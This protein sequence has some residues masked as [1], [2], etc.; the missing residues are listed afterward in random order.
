MKNILITGSKGQLGNDLQVLFKKSEL[1]NLVNAHFT[2]VDT[3]DICDKNQLHAIFTKHKFAYVVNCAA[4]TAVDKAETEF[5]KAMLVNS[6]APHLL[7]D[8]CNEFETKLIHISTDYVFDG[9]K[10]TPY[11]EEDLVNPISAYGKSK[12]SGEN[13]VIQSGCNYLIIRTSWLY[14]TFGNNFV[15]TIIRVGNERPELKVV[16]DQ[17]G[18]PTYAAD[19]ANAILKIIWKV[20]KGEKQFEQGIYHFSNE[21]VCSWYDFAIEIIKGKQLKCKVTPVESFE[22]PTPTKRPAYSVLNKRKLKS[23]FDITIPHWRDSLNSCLA[24]L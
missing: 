17:I 23:T 10:F 1:K 12:L 4:Y 5:E 22:Y 20:E 13:T 15:K 3:L 14:S 8:I 9:N 19:L 21:G 18:S 11:T 24:G 2:D 6:E 16:F 7:A